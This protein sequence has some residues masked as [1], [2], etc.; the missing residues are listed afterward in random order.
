VYVCMYVCMYVC[1]YIY[2][3][4]EERWFG[5]GDAK[6]AYVCVFVCWVELFARAAIFHFCLFGHGMMKKFKQKNG[7]IF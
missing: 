4:G 7:K 6:R 3:I 2:T 1:I 5:L